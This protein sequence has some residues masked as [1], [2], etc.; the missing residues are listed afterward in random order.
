MV[1]G[2]TGETYE[3]AGQA[4]GGSKGATQTATAS[5]VPIPNVDPA[6]IEAGRKLFIQYPC[7]S[8][9]RMNGKGGTSGPD[10]THEAQR[11]AGIEWHI[12]HLKDPQKMKPNSDMPSFDTLSAK[13]LKAIAA[14]LATR[15]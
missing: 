15:K 5:S 3:T 8:C 11:Q 7:N 13:D 14:Y 12:A 10:L 1:F 4:P 2:G 9:H 6:T